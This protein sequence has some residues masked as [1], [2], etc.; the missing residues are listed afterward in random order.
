M[1]GPPLATV[2]RRRVA[3][4]CLAKGV[5]TGGIDRAKLR[6]LPRKLGVSVGAA[7]L[8]TVIGKGL[9]K[10]YEA[11][12]NGNADDLSSHCLAEGVALVRCFGAIRKHILAYEMAI[13]SK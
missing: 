2:P 8:H 11:L 4:A 12:R 7:R 6:I 1:R 13:Y 10:V 5:N 9:V 3:W